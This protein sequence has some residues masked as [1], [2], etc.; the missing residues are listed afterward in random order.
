MVVLRLRVLPPRSAEAAEPP[1]R[2]HA[3]RGRVDRK[4]LVREARRLAAARMRLLSHAALERAPASLASLPPPLDP[5]AI[6]ET[7]SRGMG[8]VRAWLML[9]RAPAAGAAPSL[10]IGPLWDRARAAGYD[11]CALADREVLKSIVVSPLDISYA[12]EDLVASLMTAI[13][14]R[15]CVALVHDPVPRGDVTLQAPSPKSSAVAM[16]AVASVPTPRHIGRRKR[17][18]S[19]CCFCP[20][21]ALFGGAELSEE[22]LGPFVNARG[23]ASL[24]LHFTCAC[25]APQVYSDV[26]TG[27][28][29][30]VY[31]EYVRGRQLRCFCCGTKGATVGCYVEK[32]KKTF[33]FRCLEAAGA[34][35]VEKYFA[36]FCALHAH[37]AEL[38]SYQ[39]MLEAATIADV[40][41]QVPRRDTT[42][43]LDTPHSKYTCLRRGETELIFSA[44]AGICSHM[45]V[46]EAAKVLFSGRRRIV[47][48]PSHR[49][50]LSDRPRRIRISALGAATGQ[51]AQL[52]RP[53]KRHVRSSTDSSG[54]AGSGVVGGIIWSPIFL[55]R[56]LERAPDFTADEVTIRKK[57][58]NSFQ[59]CHGTG[60]DSDAA[61]P[62]RP[63][64]SNGPL[65]TGRRFVEE[66]STYI[67]CEDDIQAL[68]TEVPYERNVRMRDR[69]EVV[70]LSAD[71][72]HIANNRPRLALRIAVREEG[73]LA[74]REK[75]E[76]E[77]L[78]RRID[79]QDSIRRKEEREERL[80]KRMLKEELMREQAYK[81]AGTTSG[82]SSAAEAG[83]KIRSAWE[84]FL[85]EQL[86][87]E[88]AVRPE[89]DAHCA[90]RNIA[91]LWGLLTPIERASYE[92]RAK[93]G[94]QGLSLCGSAAGA[95][96]D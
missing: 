88:R 48:M 44:R 46:F 74:L 64:R 45:G 60:L 75:R 1:L 95:S 28:L 56:N 85:D 42:H 79:V 69:E 94:R 80:R 86:P 66:E 57:S 76:H 20:D 78:K 41:S 62:K 21:P 5:V 9:A 2:M 18:S 54:F 22:L 96:A 11:T 4:L 49:L 70:D 63:Y 39:L 8:P 50:V 87:S 13:S 77:E 40:T 67:T 10:A 72:N 53:L 23:R 47:L 73:I 51:L 33:H 19:A 29:H 52:Q 93:Q 83:P 14:S 36:A 65:N 92:D 43:G 90:M 37:L 12:S 82:P 25:W 30:G 15:S 61:R 38:E 68:Q 89:D 3:A 34:R 7:L 84:T 91:R 58:A 59:R 55:L 71:D 6:L 16:K 27:R 24:R 35:K 26:G 17:G 81:L 31:D 32:C